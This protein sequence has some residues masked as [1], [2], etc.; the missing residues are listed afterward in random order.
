MQAG[1]LRRAPAAFSGDDFEGV[2]DARHAAHQDRLDDA[3]L[4]NR[5]RQILEIALG[6]AL[7]RV[8]RVGAQELDRH[9]ALAARALGRRRL[10]GAVADQRGQSAPEARTRGLMFHVGHVVSSGRAGQAARS[11]RS[12]WMTSE[13]RRR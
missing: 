4:P 9:T 13:A 12:R 5:V 2:G 3:T 1:R 10:V 8:A 11:A 6:E 7:A